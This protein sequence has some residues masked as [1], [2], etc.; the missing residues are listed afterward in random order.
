MVVRMARRGYAGPSSAAVGGLHDVET[1][2]PDD[3]IAD[4]RDRQ[5]VV[6]VAIQ[7]NPWRRGVG[8]GRSGIGALLD[9]AVGTQG[10]ERLGIAG[11]DFDAVAGAGTSGGGWGKRFS[12]IS[13]LHD[14]AGGDVGNLAILG[15]EFRIIGAGGDDLLPGVASVISAINAV[16]SGGQQDFAVG[17]MNY[18]P[19][20][21]PVLGNGPG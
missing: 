7:V 4:G 15:L 8:P 9:S 3:F 2:H 1:G 19:A 20:D 18:Q 12:C 17:R 16:T 10:V 5:Y 14:L 13:A 11:S 6:I 21:D